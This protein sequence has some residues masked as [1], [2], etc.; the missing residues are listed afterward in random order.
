MR[1]A[2]WGPFVTQIKLVN[3]LQI[4]YKSTF[5]IF[6]HMNLKIFQ[7]NYLLFYYVQILSGKILHG[8]CNR[9]FLIVDQNNGVQ[10][11]QILAS[12]NKD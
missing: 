5:L 11:F 1:V 10:K 12:T 7:K 4:Y 9:Q 2:Q 3:E 8:F 6:P